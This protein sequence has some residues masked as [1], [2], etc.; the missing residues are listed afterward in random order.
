MKK[1]ACVLGLSG[2]L[3]LGG[4]APSSAMGRLHDPLPYSR[5]VPITPPTSTINNLRNVSNGLQTTGAIG[6]AMRVGAAV[7]RLGWS[8]TVALLVP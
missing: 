4:I 2:A 1:I 7:I 3:L 8:G 6:T 5:T